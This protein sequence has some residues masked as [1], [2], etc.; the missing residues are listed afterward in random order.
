MAGR[1]GAGELVRAG[2]V[3]DQ[4]HVGLGEEAGDLALTLRR[5]GRRAAD[6]VARG[7]VGIRELVEL[8]VTDFGTGGEADRT[9]REVENAARGNDRTQGVELGLIDILG[10]DLAG[11]DDR[12][13][14]RD[15]NLVVAERIV[16][17]RGAEVV[18]AAGGEE[19]IVGVQQT[20]EAGR[21][22]QRV[23][24][25]VADRRVAVVAVEVPLA[26]DVFGLE[27]GREQER[28]GLV[29]ED[30]VTEL[31]ETGAAA[32]RDVDVERI[33][34]I[35]GAGDG[36]A[37]RA[38][39]DRERSGG[40][41]RNDELG[42]AAGEVT[43]GGRRELI[44][45]RGV[46]VVQIDVSLDVVR[47]EDLAVDKGEHA[48]V[49]AAGIGHRKLVKV[50]RRGAARADAVGVRGVETVVGRGRLR[51]DEDRRGGGLRS[52][53]GDAR[54]RRGGRRD[55]EIQ[56]AGVRAQERRNLGILAV[57]IEDRVALVVVEADEGAGLVSLHSGDQRS[58]ELGGVLV[59]GVAV[60]QRDLSAIGTAA[61][62]DIDDTGDGIGA[63]DG[64]RTVFEDFHA[65]HGGKRNG[66]KVDES[67]RSTGPDGV[68][69]DATAIDQHEGRFRPEA[70]EGDRRGGRRETG[71]VV[72]DRNRATVGHRDLLE[73]LGDRG[74]AGLVDH[75]AV[76]AHHRG[77]TR[78]DGRFGRGNVGTGD[79][80]FLEARHFSGLGSG[81]R[82]FRR[83]GE[84]GNCEGTG[85]RQ[86]RKRS[87]NLPCADVHS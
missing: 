61:E 25:G 86:K 84:T 46:L 38:A 67:G 71:R 21:R 76:D 40:A 68:V 17:L 70:A 47:A 12:G 49:V 48:P 13:V 36:G 8:L 7:A 15:R 57:G 26:H 54:G 16:G 87:R 3:L 35:E 11:I 41:G 39:R 83:L 43:G 56:R 58:G 85:D 10:G 5:G 32:T 1:H 37:A 74:L 18:G 28:I 30:A 73:E 23:A 33:E 77:H 19:G 29:A 9:G 53:E 31:G 6:E 66:V 72:R 75:L 2:E 52:R 82:S 69:G 24:R 45:G 62:F 64:G 81:H 44:L 55:L 79:D 14:V 60:V 27:T 63:V 20:V 4:R 22:D 50:K 51:R 80:V 42:A 59:R 65:V 78:V 34:R